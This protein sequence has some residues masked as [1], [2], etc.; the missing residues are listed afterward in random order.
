[1]TERSEFDTVILG[2]GLTGLSY[3]YHANKQIPIFE[4]EAAVGGLTRTISD[5][6]YKFDLAPHLLHFRSDEIRHLVLDELGMKANKHGR[7][8][9]IYFENKLMPYPFELHLKQVS[10]SVRDDCLAG[11]DEVNSDIRSQEDKL[12]SGSFENYTLQAFGSGISKHY[13]LPYNRKIWDTDPAEMTCEWMRFLPTA[14]MEKIRESAFAENNENFGYN[15]EFYYPSEGGMQDMANAFAARLD[16]V[17]LEYE[18]TGID[19]DRRELV[20]SNGKHVSYNQLI[21]TIPLRQLISICNKP[22]LASKAGDLIST[23]VYIVNV[24]IKGEVPE[25]VHWMYFPSPDLDFFRISLP[26]NYFDNCAPDGEHIISVEVSS[27]DPIADVSEL[28]SRIIAQLRSVDVFRIDEVVFCHTDAIAC[29]YCIYDKQRTV[30]VDEISR[31]LQNYN[32]VS[33]GRYGRWEYSA[34]EDAIVYG[35]QLAANDASQ[36][37]NV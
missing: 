10:N 17:S 15:T 7:S 28:E 37:S 33:T 29:A 14:D 25:G 36:T 4:K 21:S 16:N 18:A 13:L 12:R 23:R 27:R 11:L 3:S 34:M 32:I 1:M 35:K 8:A 20:F 24:V 9:R 22:E 2:A 26:K 5:G 30:L 6:K 19:L 31:E